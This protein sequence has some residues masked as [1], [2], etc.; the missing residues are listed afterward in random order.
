MEV[1]AKVGRIREHEAEKQSFSLIPKH[2]HGMSVNKYD[3]RYS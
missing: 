1:T 2:K 3:Y